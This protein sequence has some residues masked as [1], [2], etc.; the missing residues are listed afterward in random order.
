MSDDLN[1]WLTESAEPHRR[2]PVGPSANLG[3]RVRG[4]LPLGGGPKLDFPAI[5][6]GTGQTPE[7]EAIPPTPRVAGTVAAE[8]K[9]RRPGPHISFRGTSASAGVSLD[10]SPLLMTNQLP[11]ATAPQPDAM[12]E[13][14]ARGLLSC[15]DLH[16]TYRKG[17]VKVSVLRGVSLEVERGESLAIVGQSGSGKSTLL[18]LLGMLDACDQGEIYFQGNRIDNLPN[19]SRD[20]LR[21][22]YLGMIFQFYHL[23]PELTV[24]EN[25]LVPL[26]IS[27]SVWSFF[28]HRKVFREKA[29][30]LLDKVGL[31][32]RLKHKPSELSGGEMQ[33]AAIAR[34]LMAEPEVL[35]ADEPTGNLDHNTGREII[36][37]LSGLREEQ[38]LTII[39]VTHDPSIAAEADRVV[40]LVDGRIA[41]A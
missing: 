24:L 41:D 36:D 25:V 26:M 13:T 20:I 19:A 4:G 33:R 9:Q 28:R 2:A 7:P 3:P 31:G 35:L 30:E 12:P 6:S 22:S 14:S 15:N 27:H 10:S 21:N 29:T 17:P 37:L 39:L 38:R 8:T 11:S 34:A 32:H 40:R 18:H 5:A 1:R 23:L 16:K